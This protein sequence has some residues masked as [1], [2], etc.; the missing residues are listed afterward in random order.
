MGYSIVA[1]AKGVIKKMQLL[2]YNRA[3][4]DNYIDEY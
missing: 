4:V 1:Y 3:R 2:H